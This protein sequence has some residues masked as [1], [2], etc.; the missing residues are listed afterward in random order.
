MLDRVRVLFSD[1]AA[2]RSEAVSRNDLA[3]IRDLCVESI[4]ACGG[5]QRDG[6]EAEAACKLVDEFINQGLVDQPAD[7][8]RLEHA[9]QLSTQGWAGLLASL[10]IAPAWQLRNAPQIEATPL[11]IWPVYAS[12]LLRLPASLTVAGQAD[13]LAEHYVRRLNEIV[14]L[15]E[16]NR[17]SGAVRAILER[18]ARAGDCSILCR[19]KGSPRE[20][21]S[22]RGRLRAVI[23]GAGRQEEVFLF[24]RD[25]RRLKVGFVIES[26]ENTP[27]VRAAI[28]WF[29]HL[30]DR[31]FETVLF[32]LKPAFTDLA[33]HVQSKCSDS[34]LIGDGLEEAVQSIRSALLDVVVYFTRSTM[35][36]DPVSFL[37]PRRSAPLQIVI[38]EFD[39]SSGLAGA[40]LAI[41]SKLE[42]PES[43]VA[44]FSERLAVLPDVGVAFAYN[45]VRP[46]AGIEWS[47][48]GMGIPD[49]APIYIS[50]AP[51]RELT[52][53]WMEGVAKVLGQV[54][55]ARLILYSYCESDRND[56]ELGRICQLV[57]KIIVG[58]GID[59]GR[60]IVSNDRVPSEADILSLL[61]VA[62][63]YL[64]SSPAGIRE[65]VQFALEAG[66]PVVAC[67]EEVGRIRRAVT[68]LLSLGMGDW[69]ARDLAAWVGAAAEL[70]CDVAKRQGAREALG[71]ALA[72]SDRV[73]DPVTHAEAFGLLVETAFDAVFAHGRPGFASNTPPLGVVLGED[74]DSIKAEARMLLESGLAPEASSRLSRLAGVCPSDV[75]TRELLQS[76]LMAELRFDRASESL[77]AYVER[78]ASDGARWFRLGEALRGAGKRQDALKAF[79]VALRLKPENLEGWLVL[80]EL[81]I[82]AGNSGM[83]K[84]IADIAGRL[85]PDDLRVKELH[86]RI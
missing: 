1:L 30:D 13:A 56:A 66:L 75:E 38:D 7:G 23:D 74:A 34:R 9:I 18:Y 62:D 58:H 15:A 20:L 22:L 27:H 51:F 61:K 14:K 10:L 25:G 33:N 81:A 44:H 73:F 59:Q 4:L 78:Q 17:G 86:S 32:T 46:T 21:M 83:L 47:R 54:P 84:D 24:P 49:E 19:A 69:V 57:E 53:E 42:S 52:P 37:V 26:L 76:A 11:W 5:K 28:P 67:A 40:D 48:T 79:E 39:V 65:P 35:A 50:V 43:L 85:A 55:E 16:T 70:G 68:D 60:V 82:E 72:R 63:I 41:V 45:S 8:G 77:L 36:N 29:E 64:A 2:P 31:R 12:S 3:Q 80:G 71:A 6:S